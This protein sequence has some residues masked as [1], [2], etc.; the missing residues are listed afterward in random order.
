MGQ[1]AVNDRYDVCQFKRW[2][3]KC[4]LVLFQTAH[5]TTSSRSTHVTNTNTA[6]KRKKKKKKM[7]IIINLQL[8]Q[9]KLCTV[10]GTSQTGSKRDRSLQCNIFSHSPMVVHREE[11]D[12]GPLYFFFFLFFFYTLWWFTDLNHYRGLIYLIPLCVSENIATC[13]FVGVL[14]ELYFMFLKKKKEKKKKKKK[15]KEKPSQLQ[16]HRLGL[17][18]DNSHSHSLTLSLA[19][20]VCWQ[21]STFKAFQVSTGLK[22]PFSVLCGL[23]NAVRNN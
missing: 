20:C 16:S 9:R 14:R 7:E 19:L 6:Q 8:S 13:R 2:F 18:K 10:H 23:I 4:H 22:I 1:C 5:W 15:K 3:S 11:R 17:C 21:Q 12:L